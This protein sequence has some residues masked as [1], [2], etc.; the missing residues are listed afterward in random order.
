ML[1]IPYILLRNRLSGIIELNEVDWYTQQDSQI[2][3]QTWSATIGAYIRF[4]DVTDME[5]STF[6]QAFILKFDV[7]L[8]TENSHE[9]ETEIISEHMTVSNLIFKRIQYWSANLSDL[10]EVNEVEEEDL[11]FLGMIHRI[12]FKPHHKLSN[13]IKTVQTFSCRAIDYSAVEDLTTVIPTLEIS[14]YINK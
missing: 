10:Q 5:T 3:E 9:G 13:I 6:T 11:E 2:G 12:G 4:H 1:N 14:A 7:I 8:L